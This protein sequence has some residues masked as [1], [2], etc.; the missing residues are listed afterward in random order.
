MSIRT[1]VVSG[2]FIL[3]LVLSIAGVFSLLE[4][5]SIGSSIVRLLD[6]NYASINASR[7]ML[8]SLEREDSGILFLLLGTWDKGRA[9]I[10]AADTTF[11][12]NFDLAK[13]NITEPGEQKLVDSLWTSY[14]D[15]KREWSDLSMNAGDENRVSQYFEKIHPTFVRTKTHVIRLL[16]M[17]SGAMYRTASELRNKAHRAVMPGVIAIAAALIFIFTFNYFIHYYIANPII[18]MTRQIDAYRTKGIL[19]DIRVETRDEIGDLASA[20]R[21]LTTK[22]T[23]Q[24]RS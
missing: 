11:R 16:E 10:A 2:F 20:I 13:N 4:L 22:R 1:K 24:E 5:S 21:S 9:T 7:F 19:P 3:F 8:E 23:Y 14:A 6:D 12:H 18:K 17:N 15:F